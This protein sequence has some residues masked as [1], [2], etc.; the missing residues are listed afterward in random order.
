MHTHRI[1]PGAQTVDSGLWTLALIDF[2]KPWDGLCF[3][4]GW[5][6]NHQGPYNGMMQAASPMAPNEHHFLVFSHSSIK[7]SPSVWV[8]LID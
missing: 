2:W 7:P 8:R 3:V 4:C 5:D 1:E 6:M